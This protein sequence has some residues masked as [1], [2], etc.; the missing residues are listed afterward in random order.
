MPLL[1]RF[2]AA[3]VVLEGV[4]YCFLGDRLPFYEYLVR[5]GDAAARFKPPACAAC[6][7]DGNCAGYPVQYRAYALAR[8]PRAFIPDRPL[9]VMLEAEARCQFSCHYCFNQNTF[10]S[11]AP[12]RRGM[13]PGLSAAAVRDI[14]DQLAAWG[15]PR[16]RF[17]G[18]EPLLRGDLPELMDHARSKELAV[19]VNTNGY[20]LGDPARARALCSRAD[21]VLV[22]LRGWDAVSDEAESGCPG[23]FET[24]VTAAR[25]LRAAGVKT[26]RVGI[27]AT[28]AVVNNLDRVF[29]VVDSLQADRVEFYR[30]VQ[31]KGKA[32]EASDLRLLV[33]K[34]LD[35]RLAGGSAAHI[36]N[37]LPF[38]FYEEDKVNAVALGSVLAEGNNRFVVDPRG[39]CKPGYYMDVDLGDSRDLRAAWDSPFSRSVRSGEL[40]PQA[41]GGCF[42]AGKC[43]GGSRHAAWLNSGDF[44]APDPLSRAGRML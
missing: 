8:G 43:R 31:V 32:P 1:E 11:G 9:E 22:S 23:S 20:G 19:W 12:A 40:L 37:P 15:V 7:L 28:S 13:V 42:Y 16:L 39:F 36:A 6:R 10:A 35:R 41:C 4:P 26:L 29:R 17:T 44:K 18:G 33:N 34:L 27:C 24:S 14:A 2:S 38:C 21:N 25:A 3:R 5:N 30:P